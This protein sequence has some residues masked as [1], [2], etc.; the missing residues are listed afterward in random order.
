M[1]EDHVR[2]L[3]AEQEL[4]ARHRR[5]VEVRDRAELL[6]AHDAER[7][8]HGGQHDEQQR[9][10][11][12]HH[13]DDAHE[14]LVVAVAELELG[15][16]RDRHALAAREIAQVIEVHAVHVA[17]DRLA[18]VRHGA[19]ARHADLDGAARAQVAAEIG[20]DPDRDGHLAA[21]QAPLQLGAVGDGRALH[22]VVRSLVGPRVV[23]AL[24]AAVLIEHREAHVLHVHV[25]AVA[26]DQ[27]Q[28][29]RA[30][31]REG[32]ADR[33]AQ[34]LEVLAPRVREQARR[35]ERPARC[36]RSRAGR[37][38]G[39]RAPPRSCRLPPRDGR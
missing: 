33:I 4:E 24:A 2:E 31:D 3:L 27:H 9:D 17:S 7:C 13:R 12:R 18:A 34:Q 36:V 14:A 25:E 6:L 35:R 21:A 30:A 37:R 29:Q 23:P 5:D 19:V 11:R 26:E 38:L 28:D 8:Q 22:E 16:R 32:E 15:E 10:H 39:S 1:R 20:R